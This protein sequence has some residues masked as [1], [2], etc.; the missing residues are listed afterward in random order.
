GIAFSFKYGME[1]MEQTGIETKVIRAG[2]ANMFLS[3]VFR[4][5]LAD[6]SGST[7]ELYETDGALGA[8]RG[9]AYGAGLYKSLEEAFSSLEKVE[10][11]SPIPENI[12]ALEVAYENWKREL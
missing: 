9:A 6:I 12:D 1:V 3:P 5:T 7:I 2:K 10:V 4:Q 8:A 11:I